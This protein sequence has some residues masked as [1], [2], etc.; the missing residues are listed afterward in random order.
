MN[1]QFGHSVLAALQNRDFEHFLGFLG[2]FKVFE[3]F[4]EYYG[5]ITQF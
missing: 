2:F 1:L 3:D 5:K 4:Q